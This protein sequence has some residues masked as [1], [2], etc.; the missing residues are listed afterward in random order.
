MSSDDE[1]ISEQERAKIAADFI[2]HAPPGEFNEVFT[3]V[4]LLVNDDNLLKSASGSFAQYNKDQFTPCK[5]SGS[6]EQC[7]ITEHGD[8]GEGRFLD[9]R[10]KQTFKYDHLKKEASDFQDADYDRA[11]EPWRAA[12]EEAIT[13]Y[14]KTYYKFGV[15]STYGSSNGGNITIIACIESHQFQPKNFWN[16]RWRSQ[17]SV[18]FPESGGKAELTGLLKVQVHYYEDGNVQLV[19]SKEVK[20]T[21][22]TQDEQKMAKEFVKF[23]E[24]A[25]VEY[26]TA[27][28]ENFYTMKDTTFKALRRQL[29]VTRTK[30]DWNKI[31]GYKIGSALKK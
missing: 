14:H 13:S 1:Q 22:N 16:G 12:V 2:L 30:I 8:V 26:Q 20:H 31:L 5:V 4:R 27:I 9:P 7:L 18:T 23:V 15:S 17:W 24:D 6:E 3:D 21:I 28:S 10:T 29:P 19:S 11:S 25:G